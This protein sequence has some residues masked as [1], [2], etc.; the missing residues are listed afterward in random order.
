M[1]NT[2]TRDR[3]LLP[4]VGLAGPVLSHRVPLARYAL[5]AAVITVHLLLAQQTVTRYYEDGW[6][7]VHQG[8]PF[9]WAL[10]IIPGCLPFTVSRLFVSRCPSHSRLG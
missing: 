6:S 1:A 10:D 8:L 5:L 3:C 4:A 2:N 9:R 7:G